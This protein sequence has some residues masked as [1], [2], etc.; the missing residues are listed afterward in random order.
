[1]HIDVDTL[2]E[3]L[4]ILK[5]FSFPDHIIQANL[6]LLSRNPDQLRKQLS[7]MSQY[8]ELSVLYHHP[9]FA[10]SLNK[11]DTAIIRLEA[12]RNVDKRHVSYLVLF[13]YSDAE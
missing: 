10:K 4:S 5:R 1:M 12:M 13:S 7:E 6:E 2:K 11:I 3:N 9:K 8:P